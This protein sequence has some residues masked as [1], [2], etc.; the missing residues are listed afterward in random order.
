MWP[1]EFTGLPVRFIAVIGVSKAK[2]PYL[3]LVGRLTSAPQEFRVSMEGARSD[4]LRPISNLEDGT[5]GCVQQVGRQVGSG[6][7]AGRGIR[8]GLS[9]RAGLPAKATRSR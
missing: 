2:L 5:R 3:M 7:D 8:L 4:C 9:L 6:D 1:S